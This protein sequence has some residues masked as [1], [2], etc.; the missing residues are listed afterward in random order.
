[1]HKRHFRKRYVNIV[2]KVFLL[3]RLATINVELERKA[4][5]SKSPLTAALEKQ[6]CE[7]LS[8]AG[9]L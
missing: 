5:T 2:Y 4:L 3:I 1:M 9:V 6:Y 7:N 8:P